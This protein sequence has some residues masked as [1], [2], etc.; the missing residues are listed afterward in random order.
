MLGYHEPKG[1]VGLD[2]EK[3]VTS[4]G[5]AVKFG[6]DRLRQMS[7][8]PRSELYVTARRIVTRQS[9]DPSAI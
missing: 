6:Y 9:W 2:L 5:T 4:K 7:W 8:S 3:L 1:T